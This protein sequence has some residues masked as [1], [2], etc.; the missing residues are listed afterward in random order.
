MVCQIDKSQLFSSKDAL[1][2][3]HL[4]TGTASILTQSQLDEVRK[5]NSPR[6]IGFIGRWNGC[7]EGSHTKWVGTE[8]PL[9]S[10]TELYICQVNS[11]NSF[12]E[13]TSAGASILHIHR[14]FPTNSTGS[15]QI[16]AIASSLHGKAHFKNKNG[17][18]RDEFQGLM[19][20]RETLDH[21]TKPLKFIPQLGGGS[22][23]L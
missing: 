23:R 13:F 2:A 16:Q 3:R 20:S 17:S 4:P 9:L 15:Y 6:R 8:L 22:T 10:Y 21:W 14:H 1:V 5:A 19:Y 12:W 11:V 18:A 7:G